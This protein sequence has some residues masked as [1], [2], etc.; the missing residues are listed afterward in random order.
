MADGVGFEPTDGMSRHLVSIRAAT[1]QVATTP[2]PKAHRSRDEAGRDIGCVENR[3]QIIGSL[4]RDDLQSAVIEDLVDL[5]QVEDVSIDAIGKGRIF[6][7]CRGKRIAGGQKQFVGLGS[8]QFQGNRKLDRGA[9]RNWTMAIG[10][11]RGPG[12]SVEPCGGIYGGSVAAMFFANVPDEYVRESVFV[13]LPVVVYCGKWDVH[14]W[15]SSNAKRKCIRA[16][17]ARKSC[18]RT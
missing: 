1:K 17:E 8:G 11:Y 15:T 9:F 10:Y 18:R 2:L 3:R 5:E 7:D 12:A 14:Q 13:W 6:H 16:F 4:R